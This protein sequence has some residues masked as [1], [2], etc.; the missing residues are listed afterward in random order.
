M[1]MI[2]KYYKWY[3]YLV[4][5]RLKQNTKLDAGIIQLHSSVVQSFQEDRVFNS[6][7]TREQSK[8][9]I[10]SQIPVPHKN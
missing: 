7:D 2:Q 5:Q 4:G 3:L 10:V 1:V 8:S 6:K 9:T